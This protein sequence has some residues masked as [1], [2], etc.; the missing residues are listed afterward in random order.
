MNTIQVN[1][2]T[3]LP[4]NILEEFQDQKTEGIFSFTYLP[5]CSAG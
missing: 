2:L 3:P 4:Q 1:E 5:Y